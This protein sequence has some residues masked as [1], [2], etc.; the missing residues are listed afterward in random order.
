MTGESPRTTM[1][2]TSRMA[3]GLVAVVALA[4][5]AAS[6]QKKEF[7]YTVTPGASISVVND[8]GPVTLRAG[9][10]NQVLVTA[11]P[12]T[13]KVEVD[14]TQR[15]NRVDVRSHSQPGAKADEKRVDYEIQVPPDASVMVRVST[16]PVKVQGLNGDVSIE[17]ENS[18]IEVRDSHG[19]VHA[20]TVGGPIT[21]TNLHDGHVEAMSVS[22]QVTLNNVS[23]RVVAANTTAGPITFSGDCAG[24]GQYSLSSH[25]GN[26]DVALPASASVDLSARSVT[27]SVEDGF[28]L[29]P[30]AQ[31]PAAQDQGKAFAGTSNAG[32]SSLRLRTFSGKIRVKK[33]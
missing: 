10:G 17:G 13:S 2:N 5:G 32:A 22:G 4:S 33:Q 12:R 6:A 16:G 28:L 21:L 14:S 9:S 8:F 19:Q 25:S 18:P 30:A 11:T 7:R 29:K 24:G 26:I 31:P 15:G 3:L 1:Q 27:G 20:R 23:G